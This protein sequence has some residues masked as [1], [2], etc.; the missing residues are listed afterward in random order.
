M[1]FNYLPAFA[2]GVVPGLEEL[3]PQLLGLNPIELGKLN[4]TMDSILKGHSYIKSPIDVACWDVFG[5]VVGQ[6]LHLLLG[7]CYQK[8]LP[9]YFSLSSDTKEQMGSA[10]NGARSLGYKQFQI[11]CIGDLEDDL[12]GFQASWK[13]QN[14][15]N[16]SLPTQ[17][18]AGA[19]WKQFD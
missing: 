16:C 13:M 12:N 6:P 15:E 2:K 5:K 18:K 10:L 1:G 14:P 9:L 4:L 17:T 8:K 3:A 19:S 11:K 7:G